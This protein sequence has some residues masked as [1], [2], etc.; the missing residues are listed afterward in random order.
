MAATDGYS[1]S[2]RRANCQVHQDGVA[3][4][5]VLLV[6]A[7]LTAVMARLVLSDQVWIRQVA[8]A[9]A[10]MKAAQAARAA[11]RWITLLLERDKNG[12]DSNNETWAQAL[13]PIPLGDGTLSGHIEDMQDR[14]N[15]NNLVNKHGKTDASAME[16]FERLLQVLDLNEGIAQAA[17][18]WIDP[19]DARTG[20]WGAENSYY[21]T[22]NPPYSASNE[23][24]TDPAE[25]KLVRGV[26]QDAWV[27]LE[28][29]VTALPMYTNINVN[30]AKPE[31]LA[32]MI[33]NWGPPRDA[34]GRA[35][36]WINI[37]NREPVLSLDDFSRRALSGVNPELPVGLSIDSQFFEAHT[38]LNYGNVEQWIATLYYRKKNGRA[39]ILSQNREF[40]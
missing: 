4:I 32:A 18:D 16:T 21:N 3:L 36:N 5:T 20:A 23:P 6:I 13:P 2:D 22:L 19:D 24:F 25:L 35:V 39:I 29:Y 27:R 14:F 12:V 30:T 9:S 31:V 1:M 7:I 33:R 38:R 28:P 8:N 34:L 37:V 15:L 40:Q 26:N 10:Q 17:V 11:Q